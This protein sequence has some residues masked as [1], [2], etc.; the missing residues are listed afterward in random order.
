[1]LE[2]PIHIFDCYVH[3]RL[4]FIN[5]RRAIWSALSTKHDSAFRD[6]ELCMTNYAVTLKTQTLRK[7]EY[8]TEPIDRLTH[9][10]VD[11]DRNYSRRWR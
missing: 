11:Q 9:V 5:A 6:R 7:A 4:D 1:M 8:P 3:V 2:V 10:L